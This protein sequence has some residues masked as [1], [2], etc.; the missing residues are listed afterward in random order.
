MRIRL[1]QLEALVWISR[2]G[3]FRAAARR[4]NLSQ[5]AISGRI[6]ALEDRLGV[7]LIDRSA[8]RPH[9]TRHGADVVR[10]AE[11][12]IELSETI[13]TRLLSKSSLVGTIR[14]GAADSFALTHLSPL[15]ARLAS[16]HPALH[17]ELDIDF[18]SNLDRKLRAEQ[19]DIAFLN[20]PTADPAITIVSL[21]EIE[22]AWFASPRMKLRRG[23]VTPAS[24]ERLPILTNPRPSHLYRTVLGW[25]AAAGLTPQRLNTCTSLSIMAKLTAD[26]F[27]VAALPPALLG[28]EVKSGALR[29]LVSSP[30]LP[31]H[32]LTVAYRTDP[33]LGDMTQIVSLVRD[34]ILPR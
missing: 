1:G 9:V 29:R 25:F 2:L 8:A 26:G 24:L 5:P 23:R 33:A 13:E 20:A 21:Q 6:R 32:H 12:M 30:A 18:S 22:L 16:K 34:E 31:A 11:R 10:Y 27:G 17:I 4:L 28:A 14:M 3:S 7:A 15:L 19:L